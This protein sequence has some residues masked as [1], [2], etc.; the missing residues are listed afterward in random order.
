MKML[1]NKKRN[2]LVLIL[3]TII[4]CT[5]IIAFL[6]FAQEEKVRNFTDQVAGRLINIMSNQSDSTEQKRSKVKDTIDYAFNVKWMA[7]FALGISYK[8]LSDQQKDSFP[9]LYLNYL[10][11]NYFPLLVRYEKDDSYEI[12]KIQRLNDND[13]DIKIKLVTKKTEEPI[14]IKYRAREEGNSLKFLDMIVEGV[15]TLAS[16][17]AEFSSIVQRS[18]VDALFKQLEGN[19]KAKEQN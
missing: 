4:L 14:N 5:P 1:N 7:Q 15:S 9:K 19:K 11:N 17:R 8:K 3:T 13:Y 18:G 16:Q 10:L 6:S 2:I 12:V